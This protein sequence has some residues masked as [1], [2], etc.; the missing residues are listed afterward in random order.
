LSGAFLASLCFLLPYGRPVWGQERD[1]VEI[2][3]GYSLSRRT[4]AFTFEKVDPSKK[5]PSKDLHGWRAAGTIFLTNRLGVE[6]ELT[7]HSGELYDPMCAGPLCSPGNQW[8]Q[9]AR[10]SGWTDFQGAQIKSRQ[11]ASDGAFRGSA[12]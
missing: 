2:F 9:S 10:L 12:G 1:V 6:F 4:P 3:G 11:R 5:V 8:L 7:G